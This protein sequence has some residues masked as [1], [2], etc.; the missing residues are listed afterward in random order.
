M[1]R[2]LAAANPDR[3]SP[4]LADSLNY[5]PQPGRAGANC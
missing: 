4:D 3:Y 2:E 1:Y 5:L